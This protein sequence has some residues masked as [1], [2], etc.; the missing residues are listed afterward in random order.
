[1]CFSVAYV[2]FQW[3]SGFNVEASAFGMEVFLVVALIA[4]VYFFG[5]VP[6]FT[7]AGNVI[8][9][10]RFAGAT[11]VFAAIGLW[12]LI[13]VAQGREFLSL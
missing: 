12:E 5:P 7:I 11:G 4:P 2:G 13:Q 3:A 6:T 8:R 1:M 9:A 10:S